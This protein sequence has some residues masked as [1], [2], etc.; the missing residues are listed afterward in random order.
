MDVVDGKAELKSTFSLGYSLDPHV[1]PSQLAATD[2][3]TNSNVKVKD[4]FKPRK[5]KKSPSRLRRDQDRAT[6]FKL[7][8]LTFPFTGKLL[9]V[10]RVSEPAIADAPL[11]VDW[12]L[13]Q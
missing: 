7:K 13:H 2:V 6:T 11:H 12:I 5:K 3:D 10:K 9:P 4:T 1:D 8:K